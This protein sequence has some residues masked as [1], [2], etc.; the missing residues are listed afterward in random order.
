MQ[1][2]FI[3]VTSAGIEEV[4][5]GAMRKGH[6][7]NNLDKLNQLLED[8]WRIVHTAPM[9]GTGESDTFVSLVVLKKTVDSHQSK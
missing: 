9:G 4:Q 8:G 7:L 5:E 6:M 1:K 3:L 2:A